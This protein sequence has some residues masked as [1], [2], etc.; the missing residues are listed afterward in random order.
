MDFERMF[1]EYYDKIYV[2]IARRVANSQ[3]AE[4][5]TAEVFLK[6]FENPY[7][8]K[9]AQF[10]TYVYTIAGNLLKN[11]YRSVGKRR[12]IFSETELDD[13]LSDGTN[14]L[15][16][17]LTREEY[18]KLKRAL[19]KLPQR[20]YAVVYQRYYLGQ[21]FKAIGAVLDVSEDGAKKL[22]RRAL[23]ALNNILKKDE[24]LRPFFGTRVYTQ[25]EGG[26][27]QDG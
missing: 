10:S 5:L 19:V 2:Y 13:S 18:K 8:P 20:Q 12:E 7:N 17:L 14:I 25:T 27:E 21:S 1:D 4:D 16:D 9:L 22:H 23:K 3:D 24:I 26:D 6:A 15:G 11:Y